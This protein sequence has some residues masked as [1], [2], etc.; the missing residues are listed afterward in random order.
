MSELILY[1]F[2][3]S[4]NSYKIRLLLN[5]LDKPYKLVKVDGLTGGSRTPGFYKKNVDRR[6]PVLE[7]ED[8]TTLA[9]SNAILYYLSQGT[10]YF[11]ENHLEQTQILRW[12]FFEQDRIEC[13]IGTLRFR[14]QHIDDRL[15]EF[16]D[17]LKSRGIDAL[18]VMDD[19]LKNH[20]F[21]GLDR[22]TIADIAL[23]GY[24]HV[25]GEAGIELS[26]FPNIQKWIKRV[27]E[28]ERFIPFTGR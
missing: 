24:T 20:D 15:M 4:G 26:N 2:P 19:H 28:R 8:G 3:E 13:H 16:E 23:Y 17:N 18:G 27:E 22:F 9:E 14:L 25:A 11:S 7:L 10:P 21:F 5:L 1:D 6:L 12:M